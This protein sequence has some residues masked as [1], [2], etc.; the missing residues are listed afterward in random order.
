MVVVILSLL[1]CVYGQNFGQE[2]ASLN[3]ANLIRTP[4]A[5]VMKVQAQVS[6]MTMDRQQLRTTR[7]RE[8]LSWWDLMKADLERDKLSWL[9]SEADG[10]FKSII[11]INN[12]FPGPLITEVNTVIEKTS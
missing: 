8:S 3:F 7:W 5:A 2:L 4:I 11:Y 10:F 6:K 12:Q 9:W 1:A